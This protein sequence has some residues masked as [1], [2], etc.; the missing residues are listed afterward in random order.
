MKRITYA[1]ILIIALFLTSCYTTEVNDQIK[2]DSEYQNHIEKD[3]N[4]ENWDYEK[5]PGNTGTDDQIELVSK[6]D[7]LDIEVFEY[8]PNVRVDLS[9]PCVYGSKAAWETDFLD[10]IHKH[11]IVLF[12][13]KNMEEKDI[14]ESIDYLDDVCIND[15]YVSW[16][17]NDD[18][19]WELMLYDIQTEEVKVIRS[20]N[21][22]HQEGFSSAYVPRISMYEKYIVW[23]EALTKNDKPEEV[24]YNLM[25]YDLETMEAKKISAVNQ[26]KN[27]YDRIRL[28]SSCVAWPDMVDKKNYIFW[29]NL[30]TGRIDKIPGEYS[31]FRPCANEKYI[32]YANGRYSMWNTLFCFS[33]DTGE[34]I[35]VA[36][37]VNEFY[38]I[39]KNYVI[40]NKNDQYYV[41]S[42][43]SQKT[44][45]L[46]DNENKKYNF[47][48]VGGNKF[49][50]VDDDITLGSKIKIIVVEFL[51]EETTG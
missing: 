46:T 39:N 48:R 34:T 40:Y 36:S 8:Q 14:Y 20:S 2:R 25:C 23:L 31:T 6:L 42:L 26:V 29:C 13:I 24:I 49:I 50:F 30:D 9:Y 27:P 32:L 4:T 28:Q 51:D 10:N 44:M 22:F 45:K 18:L 5:S 47:G 33:R 3:Q 43:I 41:Y 15:K 11:R 35:E 7:K 12:Y 37:D 16:V 17:K 38:L 19:N 21:N 1:I